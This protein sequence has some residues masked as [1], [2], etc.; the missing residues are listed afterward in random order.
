MTDVGD[1]FE[2][3]KRLRLSMGVSHISTSTVEQKDT[4]CRPCS[5]GGFVGTYRPIRHERGF[6]AWSSGVMLGGL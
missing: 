2:I 1:P 6:E 5:P 3:M 4:K